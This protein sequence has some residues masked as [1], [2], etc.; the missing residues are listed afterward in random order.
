MRSP[1]QQVDCT[2]AFDTTIGQAEPANL[3]TVQIYIYRAVPACYKKELGLRKHSSRNEWYIVLPPNT[4]TC[5]H[6]CNAY[7]GMT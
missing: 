3:N 4:Y 6:K 5:V 1:L 2:F 7:I